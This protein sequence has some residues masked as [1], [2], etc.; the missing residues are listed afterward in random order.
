MVENSLVC[1]ESPV[2][3]PPDFG[4][5]PQEIKDAPRWVL[6]KY[7][8]LK[9]VPFQVNDHNA[10]STNSVTWTTFEKVKDAYDAAPS[11]YSGVGFVL[12]D[13]WAGVDLDNVRNKATGIVDDAALELVKQFNTYAEVSPSGTGVKLF[14]HGAWPDGVPHRWP[15]GTAGGIEVYSSGRYFT[16]TGRAVTTDTPVVLP[17]PVANIQVALTTL[18]ET[19]PKKPTA[20]PPPRPQPVDV[21]V[22]PD[23]ELLDRIRTSRQGSKFVALFDTGDVNA[24]AYGGDDSKADMALCSILM[25]WTGNDRSRAD[26]LFRQSALMRNKWDS[27]RG[28]STYG[29]IT[30]A[31]ATATDGG[32]QPGTGGELL[33]ITSMAAAASVRRPLSHPWPDA[34]D[35][36]AF[37]GLAGRFVGALE[38][39]TEADPAAILIQFLVAVG[40]VIGRTAHAVV[41]RDRHY[42]NEFAV[43]VG[44]SAKARKGTSLA[45]VRFTLVNAE[46][47]W[48][49][50]CVVS[51]LATGEGLIWRVR[52]PIEKKEA[53]RKNGS[54]TGCDM[55]I[56]DDGVADKRLLVTEPEFAGVLKQTERHGNTLSSVVRCAWD[57]GELRTMTKTSPAKATGAHVSVIGHITSEELKRLLN[58]TETFNGFANRFLWLCVKRSKILPEGG[59]PDQVGLTE[60]E[61][62]LVSVLAFARSAGEIKRDDQARAVWRSVYTTLSGERYGLAGSLLGRAEA[63]VLRLSVI[64]AVLDKSP[65][66]KPDHL[67]AALAVWKYCEASVL[68]VFGGLTGNPTADEIMLHLRNADSG[69]SRTTIRDL[70]GARV[71]SERIAGA[72]DLLQEMGLARSERRDTAG[73]A[74]EV[75]HATDGVQ[76]P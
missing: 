31:K 5:I 70:V 13:G 73:R 68:H 64:Y 18:A 9:K 65:E 14:G 58:A 44:K 51:G 67:L 47:D 62:E 61:G 34:L 57:S 46:T 50:N 41:E 59:T 24:Y 35:K 19:A 28:E 32:Y 43:L 30:L 25:W 76:T 66:V 45:Q 52:D 7:I 20:P 4:S 53:V 2:V 6:W 49:D 38:P 29:A 15:F 21:I 40:N 71:P 22:D 69:L 23:V 12:G 27:K 63:H 1:Q 75:W 36:E 55:V 10:S 48:S 8:E 72:L 37:H 74:A 17:T 26:S 54:V 42:C 33:P 16:V 11:K 56:D 3:L 60:V 39:A